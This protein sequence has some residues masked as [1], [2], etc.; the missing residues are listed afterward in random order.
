MHAVLRGDPAARLAVERRKARAA[1]QH[2]RRRINAITTFIG[3]V[4]GACIAG[5]AGQRWL[6]GALTG[7]F[8]G[9]GIGVAVSIFK[10]RAEP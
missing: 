2:E 4:V 5:A 9:M 6:D 8:V 1:A 7:A 10:H 3:L